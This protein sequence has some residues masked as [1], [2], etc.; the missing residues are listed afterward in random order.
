MNRIEEQFEPTGECPKCG[1]NMY[2]KGGV[3]FSIYF[4]V[5]DEILPTR[6]NPRY[7]RNECYGC[8]YTEFYRCEEHDTK[9]DD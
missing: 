2:Y 1:D 8:G 4:P 5:G 9:Q 7:I 6:H 3:L